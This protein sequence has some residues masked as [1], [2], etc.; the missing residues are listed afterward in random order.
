MKIVMYFSLRSRL[1]RR[2]SAVSLR[3]GLRI[4]RFRFEV[5]IFSS[6]FQARAG[7][8]TWILAQ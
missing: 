4:L 5:G 1:A 7:H 8:T 3:F 2:W 6:A